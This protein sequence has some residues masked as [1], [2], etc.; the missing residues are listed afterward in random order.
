MDPTLIE[1]EDGV[2]PL[3]WLPLLLQTSD[4][5]FPTGSYAHSLGF[6][7][8]VRLGLA[9]DEHTL[10][11]F[12]SEHLLPSLASF[13][14]PYLR[15]ARQAALAQEWDV[16]ASLDEEVGASKA[17][18]GDPRSERSVGGPPPEIPADDPAGR[19]PS[20]PV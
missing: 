17:G 1:D 2:S 13:E 12:L 20:C 16:L 18:P 14:L 6:E 3:D 11:E 15:L 10:H 7:E 4:A 19:S 8:C 5:L 9:R